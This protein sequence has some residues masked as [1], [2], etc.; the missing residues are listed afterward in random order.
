MLFIQDVWLNEDFTNI[1][2]GNKHYCSSFNIVI[3]YVW[4]FKCIQFLHIFTS[5]IIYDTRCNAYLK[6]LLSLSISG[7]SGG[8]STTIKQNKQTN[9]TYSVW[10]H[11]VNLLH[12]ISLTFVLYFTY[13][14]YILEWKVCTYHIQELNCKV[15]LKYSTMSVL[16]TNKHI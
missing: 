1:I 12:T 2:F 16:F 10:F 5:I 11:G 8:S 4:S 7:L 9:C 6:D 13:F 14:L 15:S 3:S